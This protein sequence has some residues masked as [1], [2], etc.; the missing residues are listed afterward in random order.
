MELH[1]ETKIAIDSVVQE[2]FIKVCIGRAKENVGP[3][4]T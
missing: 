3:T 4:L 2:Y 1:P